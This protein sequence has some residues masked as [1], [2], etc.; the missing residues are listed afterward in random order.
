MLRRPTS[1]MSNNSIEM[2]RNR[3][4]ARPIGLELTGCAIGTMYNYDARVNF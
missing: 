1:P 3:A 2:V 4:R